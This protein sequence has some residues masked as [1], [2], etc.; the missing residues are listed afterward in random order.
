[1]AA[2]YVGAVIVVEVLS[3]A[4]SAALAVEDDLVALA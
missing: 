1:M 2:E 4:N 3:S